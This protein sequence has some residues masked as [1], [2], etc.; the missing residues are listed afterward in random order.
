MED[1]E[2]D[3]SDVLAAAD[4]DSD[5]LQPLAHTASILGGIT[6]TNSPLG[7]TKVDMTLYDSI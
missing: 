7:F 3:R 2:D 1:I 6:R 4:V 5:G